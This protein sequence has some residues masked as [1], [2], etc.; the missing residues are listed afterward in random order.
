MIIQK[1][2]QRIIKKNLLMLKDLL[3]PERVKLIYTWL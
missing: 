3:E 1:W 2:M